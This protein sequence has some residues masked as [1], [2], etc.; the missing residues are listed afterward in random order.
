MKLVFFHWKIEL[1]NKLQVEF[2]FVALVYDQIIGVVDFTNLHIFGITVALAWQLPHTTDFY[3]TH[4]STDDSKHERVDVINKTNKIDFKMSSQNKNVHHFD[5]YYNRDNYHSHKIDGNYYKYLKAKQSQYRPPLN[6]RNGFDDWKKYRNNKI[7]WNYSHDI[8]PALRMRRHIATHN[9][10]KLNGTII[11]P[12]VKHS[13][14][15]HRKT[16]FNLYKS[17]EKYLNAYVYRVFPGLK[18]ELLR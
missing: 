2:I 16:R 12:E 9:E 10:T 4:D 13:L 18:F 11:H 15:H 5:T 1:T 14:M 8:Y 17:I 6:V 3:K 7:R